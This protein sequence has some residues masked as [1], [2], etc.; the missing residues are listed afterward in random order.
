MKYFVFKFE[1]LLHMNYFC[2]TTG[3]LIVTLPFKQRGQEMP[4]D[5]SRDS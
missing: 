5:V 2:D 1:I 3:E 4:P